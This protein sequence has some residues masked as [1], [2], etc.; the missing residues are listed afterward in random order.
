MKREEEGKEEK[1][2]RGEGG[3]EGKQGGEWVQ[4]DT[5]THAKTM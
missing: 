2:E 5:H 1:W 4:A 3:G